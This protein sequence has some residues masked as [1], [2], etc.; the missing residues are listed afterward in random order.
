MALPPWE[1]KRITDADGV[2]VGPGVIRKLLAPL[3]ENGDAIANS[4]RARGFT[5][6]PVDGTHCPLGHYLISEL[7]VGFEIFVDDNI[8][9]VTAHRPKSGKVCEIFSVQLSR[10]VQRFISK[11]DKG[12]YPDLV[13]FCEIDHQKTPPP[14]S[15]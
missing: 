1:D 3:G 15:Q 2:V 5:G 9:T 4:L 14:V 11:F 13:Q 12:L 10:S 8:V 6:M 7:P